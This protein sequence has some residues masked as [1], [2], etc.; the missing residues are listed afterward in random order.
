MLDRLGRATEPELELAERGIRPELV[1]ADA[2]LA[3]TAARALGHVRAAVGFSALAA[4]EPGEPGE[5][6]R[7]LGALSRLAR[8]SDRLVEVGLRRVPAV[9][10]RRVAR[11]PVEQPREHAE[12]RIA[13][14]RLQWRGR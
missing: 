6:G 2:E 9:G 1:E 13:R 4:L 11:E 7:E 10:R 3:C 5:R 8:Q 12:R 14:A